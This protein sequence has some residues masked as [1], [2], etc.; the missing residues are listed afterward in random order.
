MTLQVIDQ[1]FSVCRLPEGSQVDLSMPFVFVGKTDQEL[2][3]VLP[4]ASVPSVTLAREDGWRAFRFAGTLDFS[5]IGILSAVSSLLCAHR[6]SIFAVSTFDTDY[7]LVRTEQFDRALGVLRSGGYT[8][9][10][11]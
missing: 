1:D 10:A 7:I 8:I 6:I 4:T 11:L 5:L 3:V 2:S 9:E